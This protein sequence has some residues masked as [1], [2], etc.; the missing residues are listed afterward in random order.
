MISGYMDAHEET[1]A[2]A[3]GTESDIPPISVIA[4]STAAGI[5][6]TTVFFVPTVIS[7]VPGTTILDTLIPNRQSQS[8][9]LYKHATRISLRNYGH[10][11]FGGANTNT[12]EHG[13][14]LVIALL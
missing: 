13:A 8:L 11:T 9:E 14:T 4:D 10:G 2:G 1:I 5:P 6:H 12:Y 7:D 3:S